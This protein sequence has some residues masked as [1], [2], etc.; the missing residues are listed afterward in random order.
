MIKIGLDIDGVLADFYTG[1]KQ[2]SESLGYFQLLEEKNENVESYDFIKDIFAP[3]DYK[4]LWESV[5]SSTNFW[6]NLPCIVSTG[7]TFFQRMFLQKIPFY[8]ITS[9][10]GQRDSVINQTKSWFYRNFNFYLTK[11]QLI[12]CEPEKKIE[13]IRNLHLTHYVDDRPSILEALGNSELVYWGL[14]LY[15]M[16]YRYTKIVSRALPIKWIKHVDTYMS[17]IL[18]YKKTGKNSIF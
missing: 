8:L 3:E 4:K 9:R 6:E 16:D 11:D 15:G 5:C 14:N 10:R 17:D 1:I 18:D 7:N 2:L 12:L 13:F